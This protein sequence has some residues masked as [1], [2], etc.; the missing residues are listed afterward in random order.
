MRNIRVAVAAPDL[1]FTRKGGL[2]TQVERT[3]EEL[4]KIGVD[5]H[6][7]TGINFESLKSVDLCHI[8]SMNSPTYFKALCLKK[9]NVPIVYSSVMWRESSPRII[10]AA[11]EVERLLPYKIFNDVVSCRDLSL[12]SDVVLPN[13]QQEA[14]WLV[15]AIGV[16]RSK[17]AVVPNGADDHFLESTFSNNDF[18][19]YDRDFVFSSCVIYKRKNL[20]RLAKACKSLGY[21]LVL[22]GP[23]EDE[24][25]KSKILSLCDD[26]F[27]VTFLGSLDN[28][29]HFMGYLYWRA[30]VFALPSF[31]ETPGISALE[32]GLR[33]GNVVVTKVGGAQEYFGDLARYVDPYSQ[34]EITREIRSAWNNPLDDNEKERVSSH[35]RRNFSWAKV[36]EETKSI[37]MEVIGAS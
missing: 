24:L 29:S 36:A 32:S 4:S 14:D 12:I 9:L 22:A 31:Y 18:P 15:S 2:R 8:F 10:R 23:I 7:F 3:C 34:D 5:V 21:P 13:T 33:G 19:E 27:K 30:R 11:L 6:F 26:H 16:D 28:K 35:I 17:I 37:Y 25:V 1:T 20:I